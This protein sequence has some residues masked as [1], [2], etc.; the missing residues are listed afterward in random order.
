MHLYCPYFYIMYISETSQPP[1]RRVYTRVRPPY[2][3]QQRP[4]ATSS[5]GYERT[6][7]ESEP[8]DRRHINL[9]ET[10]DCVEIEDIGMYIL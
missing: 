10:Q 8:S 5:S 2:H 4:M 6:R 9:L 3:Q 1:P 7:T